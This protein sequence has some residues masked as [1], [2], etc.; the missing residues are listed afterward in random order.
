MRTPSLSG[1]ASIDRVRRLP[2]DYLL[3]AVSCFETKGVRRQI[4]LVTLQWPS[5][6]RRSLCRGPFPSA[7]NRPWRPAGSA[8]CLDDL[9]KYKE[10]P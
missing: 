1:N 8:S 7:S 5:C 6:L 4:Y 2:P 3:P 10:T 9:C